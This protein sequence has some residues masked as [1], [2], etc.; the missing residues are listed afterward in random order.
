MASQ[1]RRSYK[2]DQIKYFREVIY[3]ACCM[4]DY[5]LNRPMKPLLV[6]PRK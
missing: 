5:L 6:P 1:I 2:N 3:H 4:V